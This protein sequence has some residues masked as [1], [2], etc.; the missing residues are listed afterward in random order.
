MG[1]YLYELEVRAKIEDID[2]KLWEQEMKK[3]EVSIVHNET[4]YLPDE[5]TKK[6]LDFEFINYDRRNN[7]N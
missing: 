5:Y 1:Q 4:L 3:Y 2:L 7:Y 6:K